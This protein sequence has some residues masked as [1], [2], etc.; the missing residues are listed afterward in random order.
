MKNTEHRINNTEYKIQNIVGKIISINISKKKGEKKIPQ[1][2]AE[3]KENFGIVGDAH[4]QENSNRQVSLLLV[5]SIKKMQNLGLKVKA[6]DF[7][8][9]LTIA[10]LDFKEIKVG[11]KIIIGK[12]VELEVSQIGKVCHE[13][14]AIYYQAGDCIMPK[15]GIFAKVLKGGEIKKGNKAIIGK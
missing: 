6:G 7:A 3:L 15:E 1:E 13:K 9:N 11:T 14:C 8:E 4:A 5:E 10:D 2:M 12:D